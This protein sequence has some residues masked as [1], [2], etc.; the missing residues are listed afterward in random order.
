VKSASAMRGNQLPVS[1]A[2]WQH[3]FWIC[4]A[5]KN[6]KIAN[7]SATTKAGEKISR[8]LKSSKL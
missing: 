4:L 3:G 2:R 6:Y 1:A 7:D 8:I 5:M